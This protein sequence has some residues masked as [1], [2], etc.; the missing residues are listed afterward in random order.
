MMDGS[1]SAAAVRTNVTARVKWFNPLNGFGFVHFDDGSP[2]AFLHG[3]VLQR[4][5]HPSV[6]EGDTITCDLVQ[7]PKGLQVAVVHRVELAY[8]ASSRPEYHSYGRPVRRVHARQDH[9]SDLLH[10]YAEPDETL[11]GTV[12]WFN[13]GKGFG[14]IVPDRG[15]QDV[16]L[17]A[18]ILEEAGAQHLR[19]HQRVRVTVRQG[20]KGPQAERIELL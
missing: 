8:G 6:R 1:S 9:N 12:K 15:G 16:F 17:H 5:G 4:A 10:T 18:R 3:S 11:E 2:D 14:F 7:G 13:A 20:L 19:E